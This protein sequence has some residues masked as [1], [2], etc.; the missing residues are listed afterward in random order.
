MRARGNFFKVILNVRAGRV[1]G[2]VGQAFLPVPKFQLPG[3]G[4][5]ACPTLL[6]MR[7][8]P[9]GKVIKVHPHAWLWE[10]LENDAGF[11][12]RPMFGGKALYIDGRMTLFFCA[13]EEPWR[14]VC[15]CTERAHHA[16]LMAEFPAL[17]PHKI[18]PKWLYLPEAEECFERVAEKLVAL[19]RRR[20]ARVGIAGKARNRKQKA[21]RLKN[22]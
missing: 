2:R 8:I 7:D 22:F 10:P 19:A 14:G 13:K 3:T 21:G 15:V 12:L 9:F 1:W 16:S 17:A 5:N 11:L 6:P 4:R 20:D 18:L